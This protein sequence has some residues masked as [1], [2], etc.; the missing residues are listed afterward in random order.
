MTDSDRAHA[1]QRFSEW[2]QYADD[3]EKLIQ[4]ALEGQGPA[5]PICFHAQ[6]IAEK[7][8]KG[9]LAYHRQPPIK[10]HNLQQLLNAC[11]S[12]DPMFA[13]LDEP[14][15]QLSVY[16]I[17]TR[18]PGDLPEFTLEEAKNAY[19]TALQVKEFVLNKI[20]VS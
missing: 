16:Y 10:S 13:T 1:V 11:K 19:A 14:V 20:Q 8:L 7:Y 12:L 6:Q 5:N 17:E 4:V 18:Y 15:V 9:F 3:D 2:Q